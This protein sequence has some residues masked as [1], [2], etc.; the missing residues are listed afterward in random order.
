MG[1]K[2]AKYDGGYKPEDQ[3]I[4]DFWAF[5]K[6]LSNDEGKEFL[7]FV[8]GSPRAP[9]G[10]LANVPLTIQRNGVDSELLPTSATCYSLLL[11]PDYATKE[12]M[13]AKILLAIKNSVGFGNE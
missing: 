11:L 3:I 13:Q 7:K 8:T 4:K 12:K 10:G 1:E 6:T 2:I 5:I 9:V